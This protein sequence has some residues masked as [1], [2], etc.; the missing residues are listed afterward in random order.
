MGVGGSIGAGGATIGGGG[1]LRMYDIL[2]HFHNSSIIASLAIFAF[3][4]QLVL[5]C[6]P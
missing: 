2:T 4:S 3:V 6:N 1:M 5:A